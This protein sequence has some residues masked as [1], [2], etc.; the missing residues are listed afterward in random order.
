MDS[1]SFCLGRAARPK[2]LSFCELNSDG[3]RAFLLILFRHAQPKPTRTILAYIARRS[4]HTSPSLIS[5]RKLCAQIK[6]MNGV[7]AN[8][9]VCARPRHASLDANQHR[10]H[11]YTYKTWLPALQSGAQSHRRMEKHR[12]FMELGV[13]TQ[14]CVSIS[15]GANTCDQRKTPR[16]VS[17]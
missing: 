2:T 3:Q 13:I 12:K 6:T 16:K 10:E 8:R 1:T 5:A 4:P 7:W 14:R 11:I 9:K 15:S 17:A